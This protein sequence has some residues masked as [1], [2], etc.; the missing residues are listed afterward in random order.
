MFLNLLGVQWSATQLR[1]MGHTHW[2]VEMTPC[3]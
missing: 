3:D 2:P 1:F